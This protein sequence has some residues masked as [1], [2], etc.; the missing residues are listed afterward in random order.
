MKLCKLFTWS[1]N[2]NFQQK[3]PF[4]WNAL[5]ND[6]LEMNLDKFMRKLNGGSEINKQTTVLEI[7]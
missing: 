6:Q 4:C 2:M 3:L 1:L 5:K 7:A